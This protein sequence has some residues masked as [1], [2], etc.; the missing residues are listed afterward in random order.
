[1]DVFMSFTGIEFETFG[2]PQGGH[3]PRFTLSLKGVVGPHHWSTSDPSGF[4][5]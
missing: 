2:E 1:M 5:Y 4:L 3:N